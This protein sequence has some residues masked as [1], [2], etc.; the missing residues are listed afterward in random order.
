MVKELHANTIIVCTVPRTF[1]L[2]LDSL[3]LSDGK[4]TLRQYDHCLYGS[5]NLPGSG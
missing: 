1:V 2:Q 3:G 5:E 4:G